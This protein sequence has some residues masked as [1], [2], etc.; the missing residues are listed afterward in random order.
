MDI[1]SS[2]PE[3][4]LCTLMSLEQL[5]QIYL[6]ITDYAP[7]LTTLMCWVNDVFGAIGT[8][9]TQ[10]FRIKAMKLI[11]KLKATILLCYFLFILQVFYVFNVG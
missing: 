1:I 8:K 5:V 6:Y 11:G 4:G 3:C 7:V 9:W 10:R 2:A